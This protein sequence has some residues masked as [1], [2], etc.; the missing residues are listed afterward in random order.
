MEETVEKIRYGV[1]F[2][3]SGRVKQVRHAGAYELAKQHSLLGEGA[4]QRLT[5]QGGRVISVVS[6]QVTV[7]LN[8]RAE[9]R[10]C[11]VLKETRR[12]L[13][14]YLSYSSPG[15]TG[16][17]RREVGLILRRVVL[18]E[19]EMDAWLVEEG[20]MEGDLEWAVCLQ[21]L[22]PWI[23]SCRACICRLC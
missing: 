14:V 10:L 2:P 13:N 7:P 5:R 23:A 15:R 16:C 9:G 12:Y 19:V 21:Q 18:I 22:R 17:T 3:C 1:F 8:Q 4:V 11:Q 6:R 20:W